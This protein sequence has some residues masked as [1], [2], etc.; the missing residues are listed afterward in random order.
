MSP[1]IRTERP[2]PNINSLKSKVILGT[3]PIQEFFSGWRKPNKL[4]VAGALATPVAMH[5]IVMAQEDLDLNPPTEINITEIELAGA[6]AA[7]ANIGPPTALALRFNPFG[8]DRDC[9]DFS[10]WQEAQDFYIAAGGPDADPHKLDSNA[11]GIACNALYNSEQ[12]APPQILFEDNFDDPEIGSLL[13]DLNSGPNYRY[14]DGEYE[15]I[16]SA[17]ANAI[18]AVV[19]TRALTDSTISINARTTINESPN[20]NVGVTCRSTAAAGGYSLLVFSGYTSYFL[21][22]WD[23]NTLVP[24]A[25]GGNP[26]ILPGKQGNHIEFSCKGNVLTATVNGVIVAEATDDTYKIGYHRITAGS[27]TTARFD[28]LQ[29]TNN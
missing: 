23:D 2:I 8:K 7:D 19:S 9:A 3:Y 29:V 25:R 20:S 26:A 28:N 15:I 1:D 5:G 4:Q 10:T 16:N 17:P 6:A 12:I 18:Y 11:D 24:L 14:I 13:T 22:R 21:G 27:A